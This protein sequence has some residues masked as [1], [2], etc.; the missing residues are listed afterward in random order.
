MNATPR[1]FAIFLSF[2]SSRLPSPLTRERSRISSDKNYFLYASDIRKNIGIISLLRELGSNFLF[3]NSMIEADVY[4]F[5]PWLTIN[6]IRV[7]DMS[8][9]KRHPNKFLRFQKFLLQHDC[10]CYF[11]LK[12]WQARTYK[13]FVLPEI[14][15]CEISL[16]LSRPASV[17]YWIIIAPIFGAYESIE[18]T[19]EHK[20]RRK[21][22]SNP[23]SLFNERPCDYEWL[24]V[25]IMRARIR[26]KS[27]RKR[28]K[29]ER[30]ATTAVVRQNIRCT[31]VIVPINKLEGP[32]GFSMT[33]VRCHNCRWYHKCETTNG[34][35]PYI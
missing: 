31:Y 13:M 27:K 29:E 35:R 17:S 15:W 28:W 5:I 19:N 30:C 21:N 18:E 7:L 33:A 11:H 12:C 23:Y 6:L 16:I 1:L 32:T 10:R 9:W 24:R 20:A 22:S 3:T 14:T 8:K 2:F 26:R 25:L 4:F 34:K